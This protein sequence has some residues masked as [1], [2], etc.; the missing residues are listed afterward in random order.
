MMVAVGVAA[1]ERQ[2]AP[3]RTVDLSQS[4]VR[5]RG[6][7]CFSIVLRCRCRARP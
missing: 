5:T 6:S 4:L 1:L 3:G 2:G 7:A